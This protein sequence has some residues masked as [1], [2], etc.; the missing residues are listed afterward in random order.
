MK[1]E[2]F[3][4]LMLSAN[5]DYE[6]LEKHMQECSSCRCWVEK[7]LA[8]PPEG[9]SSAQWL[10]ATARCLPEL[11]KEVENSKE[12]AVKANPVTLGFLNGMKY[13]LVFGLAIITALAILQIDVEKRRDSA[14][15]G[16]EMQSFLEQP[17]EK[18]PEFM[19]TEFSSVTFLDYDDSKDMSFIE[20]EKIPSFIEEPE[21][22]NLWI[23]NKSG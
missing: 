10:S 7:E 16:L 2:N 15:N 13:G 12:E 14:L 18:M 11:P 22:E 6:V 3:K 4:K 1:C 19:S 21:E 17:A 23:E 5:P 8:T 9:L 20:T